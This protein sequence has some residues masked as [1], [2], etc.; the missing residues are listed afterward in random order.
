VVD[1]TH[2]RSLDRLG[3]ANA[4]GFPDLTGSE[5]LGFGL[6]TPGLSLFEIEERPATSQATQNRT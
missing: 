6:G 5:A 4:G 1:T 2:A 3:D